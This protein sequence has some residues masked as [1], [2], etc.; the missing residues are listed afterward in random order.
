M[1]SLPLIYIIMRNHNAY[2]LTSV[3]VVSLLNL[4][5]KNFK[6]VI[7]DDGSSDNSAKLIKNEFPQVEILTSKRYVEYCKGLNIGIRF[8]LKRGAEYIFLVNNDTKNFSKNY[9]EEI[10]KVFESDP[11]VGMVGSMVLNYDGKTLWNGIPK[12]KLGVQMET[13]TEGF[14]VKRE[15]FEKV[16]L[17]NEFL[18]RYFEDL[19]LIIRLREKGVQNAFSSSCGVLPL[20]Q[21]DVIKADLYT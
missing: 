12:E 6:I 19:D 15:V 3:A 1:E 21:W 10:V 18:V 4:T 17:L 9:L 7:V 20:V 5:Y 14:I 11:A 2:D 16:G 8:A 13:P